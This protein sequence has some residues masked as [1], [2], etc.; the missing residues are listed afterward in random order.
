MPILADL[1]KLVNPEGE[2]KR[3]F[4]DRRRNTLLSN[5]SKLKILSLYKGKGFFSFNYTFRA[6]FPI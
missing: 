2:D 6:Y 3:F 5:F 4:L 1:Q